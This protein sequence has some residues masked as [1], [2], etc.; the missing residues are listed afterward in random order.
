MNAWT[1][2]RMDGRTDGPVSQSVNQSMTMMMMMMMM[3]VVAVNQVM[4]ETANEILKQ[5]PQPVDMD[6]VTSKYPVLYEQSMNTVLIQEIIRSVPAD[7]LRILVSR[8][9]ALLNS[10]ISRHVTSLC[11]AL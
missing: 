6:E 8:S 11:P 5:I 9:S 4:E 7:S 1:D 2:A 10:F 3:M